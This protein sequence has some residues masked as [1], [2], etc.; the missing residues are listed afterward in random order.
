M[1]AVDFQLS[2]ACVRQIF[3]GDGGRGCKDRDD[4]N[5]RDDRDEQ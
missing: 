5:D 3:F 1:T 4:R 2:A